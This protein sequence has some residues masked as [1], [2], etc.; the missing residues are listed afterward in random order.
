[1]KNQDQEKKSVLKKLKNRFRLVVMNDETLEEKASFSLKPLNVFVF[2]GLTIILLIVLTTLLIA[3][4]ALREYIPGYADVAMQRRVYTLLMKADSL[5]RS[6]K[7]QDRYLENIRNVIEGK[8]APEKSEKNKVEASRY[9]TISRLKK[10]LADSLLRQEIESQNPLTLRAGENR[11]GI[12][13]FLFFP[14]VKGTVTS[15]FDP[16]T[17]HYG[18]DIVSNK[19]ESIKATLSGSVLFSNF[20]SE[21]G[22]VIAI[23]H[24][25]N[26]VSVY[27]HNS[28]LLKKAG[29]FVKA[30]EVIAIIGNSGELSSG[31]H[32]HFELWYNGSAIDPLKY[33]SF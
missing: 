14:P 28:A 25:N 23:Q 18:L 2:T 29:D 16:L 1:M 30:G 31:P 24:E 5:E 7:A 12:S 27:K 11:S 9:D 32:L 19:N 8:I 17:K 22:Y 21:T 20:T 26:L 13:S 6:I 33:V 4:T 15:R 3:F 10:S